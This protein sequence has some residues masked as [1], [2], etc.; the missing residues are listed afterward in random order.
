MISWNFDVHTMPICA[1]CEPCPLHHL[2]KPKTTQS[3]MHA[4]DDPYASAQCS[5]NVD[6]RDIMQH[7]SAEHAQGAFSCFAAGMQLA[8]AAK[9]WGNP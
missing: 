8:P 6:Y 1:Q 5:K 2:R 9:R 4:K 7:C 3:C